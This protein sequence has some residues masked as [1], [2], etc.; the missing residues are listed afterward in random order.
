MN[1]REQ[2]IKAN[3]R[4]F[5]S[6]SI[7]YGILF[8][9]CMYR[10]LF[11]ATFLIYAAATVGVLVLF[12]GKIEMKLKRAAALYF[13]GVILCGISTCIT[14]SCMLQW[15]N[16]CC[17]IGLLV[18]AMLR[19]FF[20]ESRW[21]I[22][23]YVLNASV[24]FFTTIGYSF[25]PASETKRYAQKGKIKKDR[26]MKLVFTGIAAA[27]GT[28]VII[29]PL[30]ISS[31]M[32]FRGLF[33]RFTGMF[34]MEKILPNLW[35]ICGIVFTAFVG[36]A[37]IYA[38][39]YASCHA[40]FP[41]ERERIIPR[42]PA[43]TGIS[44][45]AVIGG[46]YMFY[47]GVQI[48]YL[49]FGSEGKLPPGITY[50]EYARAGF[51]QLAAVAFLN[52]VMVLACMYLFEENRILKA[53]LA[54]ICGLTFIMTASA[55]Y[56]MYLYVAAYHLTFLRLLV[57]WALFILTVIMG[58]V[59]LGIYRKHFPLVR[60]MITVSVCGY[61]VFSFAR[62]DYVTA[63]YNVDHMAV[64]GEDD[65]DYMLYGLSLDV[66]AVIS[67]IEVND[68]YAK[69]D[70]ELQGIVKGQ[71]YG[72]FRTI[73]ENNEGIYLRKANYSRIRAKQTA[74]EYLEQHS[75]DVVYD[76]YYYSEY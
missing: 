8:A 46:I 19:Q 21:N 32:I 7:L 57:F 76:R 67:E 4:Y 25:L 50:S 49:F 22:I 12:L 5:G 28:L 11:G 35:T 56:R 27:L 61:L 3:F 66:S 62:P 69:D 73:S 33:E 71:L 43:M 44:F 39:F 6:I 34:R 29:L 54:L 1:D 51:W 15:L 59:V 52:I 40:K 18:L 41:A 74:D 10:N 9:F 20:D 13:A 37:L 30:L 64:I 47:C 63:K 16:W 42:C 55:A 36:F 72:Y 31:D 75:E 65:L 58:G 45:A 48:V 24:L 53:L 2:F 14:S 23:S 26:R 70:M 38:F 17:V 60:Y 68:T